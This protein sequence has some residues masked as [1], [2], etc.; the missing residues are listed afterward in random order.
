M[1]SPAETDKS[2]YRTDE[3]RKRVEPCK[4]GLREFGAEVRVISPKKP[5][6]SDNCR[7]GR[8]PADGGGNNLSPDRRVVI[9]VDDSSVLPKGKKSRRKG[10]DSD[11]SNIEHS[12]NCSAK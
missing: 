1:K 5:P 11:E 12:I 3:H 8:G 7:R 9:A 2:S 4:L 10:T 6:Q